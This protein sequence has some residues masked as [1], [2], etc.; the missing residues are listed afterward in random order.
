MK[1]ELEKSYAGL[2]RWIDSCENNFH[3]NCCWTC[4]DLFRRN[5][6]MEDGFGNYYDT[7]IEKLDAKSVSLSIPI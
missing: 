6:T 7:L 1:E 4:L 2:L 3:I 5:Y